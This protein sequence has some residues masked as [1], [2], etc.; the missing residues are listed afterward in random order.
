MNSSVA[1][2]YTVP[3][4]QRRGVIATFTPKDSNLPWHYSWNFQWSV[5]QHIWRK[6]KTYLYSL[7]FHG[8]FPV[9]QGPFGKYSHGPGSQDEEAFDFGMPVGT[10]VCATRGGIVVAFRSDV[11]GGGTDVH[12]LNRV[13]YITIKHDDGT[14]ARYE[15]LR[16]NGVLVRLGDP[17]TEGQVIGLSGATG[18]A[19]GPHLHLAVFHTLNGYTCE[20]LPITFRVNPY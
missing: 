1:L 6:P 19:N 9:T 15:H 16:H 5:G 2:P 11:D 8:K 12:W 17:I 18:H 13:N 20:T 4:S 10:P 14:Y 7:P 3:I